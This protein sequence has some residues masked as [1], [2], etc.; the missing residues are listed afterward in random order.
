VNV[1]IV[2]EN[3]I[4]IVWKQK[5]ADMLCIRIMNIYRHVLHANI[6]LRG[7][8]YNHVREVD[9]KIIETISFL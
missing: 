8:I 2:Y 5:D 3:I 4:K 9:S 6:L 1:S 7:V